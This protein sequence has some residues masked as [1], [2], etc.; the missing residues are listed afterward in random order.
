MTHWR[1]TSLFAVLAFPLSGL[2]VAEASAQPPAARRSSDDTPAPKRGQAAPP[3]HLVKLLQAPADAPRTLDKLKGKA[4]VL[5]FWGTWCAPCV[6]AF[7]H[8]NEL[9]KATEGEPVVFLAVTD[10]PADHVAAFLAKKPLA[11]WVGI[12]DKGATTAAYGV[13]S[14]PTTVLIDPD[15][16]VQGVTDPGSLTAALVKDLARRRPLTL[17]EAD[18]PKLRTDK[19][20]GLDLGQADFLVYL[21]PP[22]DLLGDPTLGPY[23]SRS[24][25]CP[26]RVLLHSCYAGE[27]GGWEK[28]PRVLIECAVPD[29]DFGYA[30]RVPRGSGV[31]QFA[32]LRQAL[33]SALGFRTR[34]DREQ[35]DQDV[36]VLRHVGPAA[37]AKAGGNPALGGRVMYPPNAVVGEGAALKYLAAWVEGQTKKPVLDETGLAGEYDWRVK[38]TSFDLDGLN[39]ALKKLGLVLTPERRKVEYIVVRRA[40]QPPRK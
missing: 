40:D 30:V 7:P 22:N 37:P 16:V 20:G 24:R 8:L 13:R 34:G 12:D 17:K 39:A 26:A 6:A 1:T 25:S 35:R 10:E 31:S 33:E 36:L 32:L 11:A 5:E 27:A 18:L 21:G 38:A 15:G 14:W 4:V 29:R 28:S 9:V 2:P 3:L 19:G 23:E